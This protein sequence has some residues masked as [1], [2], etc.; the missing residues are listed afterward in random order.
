M[1]YAD[2][3]QGVHQ[4]SL[5]LRQKDPGLEFPMLPETRQQLQETALASP[6]MRG[7]DGKADAPLHLR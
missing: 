1:P 5:L 6:E 2:L 3:S 7:H 4:R